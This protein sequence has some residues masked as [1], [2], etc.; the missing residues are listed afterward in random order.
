MVLN[1]VYLACIAFLPFPTSVLGEHGAVTAS[2]LL[3]AANLIAIGLAS[4]LLW[5]YAARHRAL[6]QPSVT[7]HEIR[8]RTARTVVP[9]L[10]M[11]PS[12][13]LAFVAPG[14]ATASWLLIIPFSAIGDR[15]F[16]ARE[17]GD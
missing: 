16:P 5:R 15:V 12:V 6:L 9:T 11:L 8:I 10:A 17:P 2:V 7:D 4:L 3:Y 13:P 14:W 1:L